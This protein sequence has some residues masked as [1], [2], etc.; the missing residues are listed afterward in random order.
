[1]SLGGESVTAV[2]PSKLVNAESV[3]GQT[4]QRQSGVRHWQRQSRVG[5][6]GSEIRTRNHGPTESGGWIHRRGIAHRRTIPQIRSQEELNSFGNIIWGWMVDEAASDEGR[7]TLQPL[8]I[9]FI[10]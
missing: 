2:E 8:Y 5:H 1:M 4:R 6:C 7:Y 9:L 3:T 10:F